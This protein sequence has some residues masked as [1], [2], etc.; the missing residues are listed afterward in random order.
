M[1]QPLLLSTKKCL[2]GDGV[3]TEGVENVGRSGEVENH[4]CW[5]RVFHILSLVK[6][7]A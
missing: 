6:L 4:C 5:T 3:T 7:K 1:E 2:H